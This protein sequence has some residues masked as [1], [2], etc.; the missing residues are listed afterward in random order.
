MIASQ[1]IKKSREYLDYVDEHIENVRQAFG[2]LTKLCDGMW[3]VG[4]DYAWHTLRRQVIEHDISKLSKEEF[5]QYRDSFYPICDED[6]NNSCFDEAW[7]NHKR[8]NK[9]HHESLK[10]LLDVVHMVVDWTAMGYKF[11]DTAR[12]YYEKNKEKISLSTEQK[13]T[14]FEIFDK[15]DCA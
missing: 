14:M 8:K 12:E 7:E 10:D 4:D 11:G 13:Q 15:T 2:E 1:Y 9:H 5:V 3:W 6:K